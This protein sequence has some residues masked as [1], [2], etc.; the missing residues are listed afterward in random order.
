MSEITTL[1][2]DIDKTSVSH[3]MDSH[4]YTTNGAASAMSNVAG[5]SFDN[6]AIFNGLAS[7][8]TDAVATEADTMDK[9]L[10]HSSPGPGRQIHYHSLGLCMKP[11]DWTST[12]LVPTLCKDDD[13]CKDE[14]FDWALKSWT[15][16]TGYGGDVG[17][18]RD[19]HVIKGPYDEN[20]ELWDCN[21]HDICNGTF[22]SD[23]SYVY[24]ATSTFPYIVGCWGPSETQLHAATC[25]SN[26]CGAVAG[27]AVLG[28]TLAL[29]AATNAF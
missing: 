21:D 15:T 18:A 26:S 1:L 11:S 4:G 29:F 22:I 5:F 25:S 27:L 9:C 17:L 14:P 19:G 23:G 12:T 20:G 6:I 24:V 8:N 7:G 16:T 28:G 13:D 2:C 3:M 10:T